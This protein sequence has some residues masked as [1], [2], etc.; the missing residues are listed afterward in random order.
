MPYCVRCGVRL[1]DHADQCPLCRTPVPEEFRSTD[2]QHQELRDLSITREV[3]VPS[4]YVAGISTMLLLIPIGISL[5]IDISLN[6]EVTWSYFA[7]ISIIMF[8]VLLVQPFILRSYRALRSLTNDLLALAIFL[9]LIDIKQPPVTWAGYPAFSLA[10]I[11][12]HL[13]IFRFLRSGYARIWLSMLSIQAYITG[14]ESLTRSYLTFG[15]S[16]Q[17]G[18]PLLLCVG[19]GA[20]LTLFFVHRVHYDSRW[21]APLLGISLVSFF[22]GLLALLA[23]VVLLLSDTPY[24]LS[25]WSFFV[26]TPAF[27]ISVLCFI[28]ARRQRVHRALR[29]RF[30]F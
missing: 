3:Q 19:A 30:H 1:E 2:N 9:V 7:M 18:T 16:L 29:R 21:N 4:R 23:E 20:S 24:S 12:V 26:M 10:L 22:T 25:G 15:W 17:I 14:I 27:A 28:G 6:G 13:F 11:V 8:W 5:I